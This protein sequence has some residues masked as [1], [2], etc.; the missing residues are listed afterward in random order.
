MF[1]VIK[2]IQNFWKRKK[3]RIMVYSKNTGE[4]ATYGKIDKVN[5]EILKLNFK[6]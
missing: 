3:K 4:R 1:I 5:G 2:Q 6:K